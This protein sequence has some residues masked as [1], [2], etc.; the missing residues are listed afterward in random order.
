MGTKY[1]SY[2]MLGKRHSIKTR[3]FMSLSRK[4]RKMP[5]YWGDFMRKL[6][7]GVPRSA[8]VKEKI[9]KTRKERIKNGLI[10]VQK[11]SKCSF[12]R[13]GVSSKN[14]LLRNRS[15]YI[16]WRN[17]VFQRDNWTCKICG[18]RS[19]KNKPVILQADHIQPFASYPNLR[20]N[21]DNGRT[22]CLDCHKKTDSYLN[23]KIIGVYL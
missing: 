1:K 7:T 17:Q 15:D 14:H 2:G 23:R 18:I 19:S 6:K 11:G 9:S 3:I 8:E 13:G 5:P 10:S 12:W 22:L 21:V 20:Y 16:E 4:G